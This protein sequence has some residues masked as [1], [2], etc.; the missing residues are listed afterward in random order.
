MLCVWYCHLVFRDYSNISRSVR[1][2]L[3]LQVYVQQHPVFICQC[4]PFLIILDGKSFLHP[5]LTL[6]CCKFIKCASG[7]VLKKRF[8]RL[9]GSLLL[10]KELDNWPQCMYVVYEPHLLYKPL[11]WSKSTYPYFSLI[12]MYLVGFNNHHSQL[13]CSRQEA[14]GEYEDWAFFTD[15]FLLFNHK[16]IRGILLSQLKHGI[17]PKPLFSEQKQ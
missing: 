9:W 16:T 14:T 13:G 12:T 10:Q 7:T 8:W 5:G 6:V 15:I 17:Q 3:Y 1:L 2:F 11:V 4:H